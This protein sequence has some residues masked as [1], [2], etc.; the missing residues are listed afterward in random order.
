MCV[1]KRNIKKCNI[2]YKNPKV[3]EKNADIYITKWDYNQRYRKMGFNITQTTNNY[4]FENRENQ[5]NTAT[6]IL[7]R[8]GASE[9]VSNQNLNKTIFDYDGRVYSNAQLSILKAASQISLNGTLKETLRYLKSQPIKKAAKTP[10]LGELWNLFT[11]EQEEYKYI[12]EWEIDY[13]AENIFA[14]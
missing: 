14:A 11:R 10:V 12:D 6:M 3:F 1:K 2:F 9:G 4:G 13:S 7:N 8:S 5:R